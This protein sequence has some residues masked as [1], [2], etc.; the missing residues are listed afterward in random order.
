M[1]RETER[2]IEEREADPN[3]KASGLES[4]RKPNG[5]RRRANMSPPVGEP[6]GS[7]NIPAPAGSRSDR[8]SER[9]SYRVYA[10][11]S[12]GVGH[13]QARIRS[14]NDLD[15]LVEAF[16]RYTESVT[17]TSTLMFERSLA[18]EK[19][20][21]QQTLRDR[22]QK[23]YPSF[24][25]LAEDHD[26]LSEKAVLVAES[27]DDRVRQNG[28]AQE[29]AVRTLLSSIMPT[30]AQMNGSLQREIS[31]LK[32]D[33]HETRIELHDMRNNGNWTKEPKTQTMSNFEKQRAELTASVNKVQALV[34]QNREFLAHMDQANKK[35]KELAQTVSGQKMELQG[36]LDDFASQKSASRTLHESWTA[37]D[38]DH[39]Q[40]TENL[41]RTVETLMEDYNAHKKR[42]EPK[43]MRQEK[44]LESLA[45]DLAAQQKDFAQYTES[46]K[47][48]LETTTQ[49]SIS[50]KEQ[51][52]LKIM[53]QEMKLGKLNEDF[54]VEKAN[55]KRLNIE[56]VGDPE[57]SDEEFK[58]LIDYIRESREKS[59]KV[60]GV[61][62]ELDKEVEGFTE[63]LQKVE[64]GLLMLG[65]REPNPESAT[66]KADET[67]H[68][69]EA[70]SSEILLSLEERVKGIAIDQ[71][72]KD[73]LVSGEVERLDNI[74]ITQENAIKDVQNELS[75]L[76]SKAFSETTKK[77]PTP[78]PQTENQ[79]K[80]DESLLLKV[81][82]LEKSFRQFK[83]TSTERT[84]SMEV[85][86][87][88]QQQRF[89]N[90]ST[91]H[92]ANSIIH[93]MQVLYP[94]HPANVHTKIDQIKAKQSAADLHILNFVHVMNKLNDNNQ[95]HQNRIEEIQGVQIPSLDQ[96]IIETTKVV[97]DLLQES[98][99]RRAELAAL[100]VDCQ[101][102]QKRIAE[103]PREFD[104]KLEDLRLA[105]SDRLEKVDVTCRDSLSKPSNN[106]SD[107]KQD[108]S[109]LTISVDSGTR[110]L[111]ELT[112]E[113]LNGQ[114]NS[115]LL[116]HDLRHDLEGQNKELENVRNSITS[117]KTEYASTTT[118]L[119]TAVEATQMRLSDVEATITKELASLHGSL[120]ILK[121]P[122]STHDAPKRDPSLVVPET[123]TEIL[124]GE[125]L[126]SDCPLA[127]KTA[128]ARS[129]RNTLVRTSEKPLKRKRGGDSSDE[130]Y[131]SD[132][133]PP[134]AR[135]MRK[136]NRGIQRAQEGIKKR[137]RASSDGGEH[138]G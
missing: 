132:S 55:L 37:Q 137:L 28:D 30:S 90:L 91:D 56:I 15:S 48:D 45:E 59:D 108:L 9:G 82:D 51:L 117:W 76:R 27:F 75:I 112:K 26:R 100:T 129:L 64:N 99:R 18:K 87:E 52:T 74:L 11:P 92:L 105:L 111:A 39:A 20:D 44:K 23:H 54:V 134:V 102:L 85:L 119:N 79:S 96:R 65:S 126:D 4:R 103:S 8:G 128:P 16:A 83:E 12:K 10:T 131:S 133:D 43:M 25:S 2:K 47:N 57:R 29:N 93:Q 84:D 50:Q 35:I 61:I 41:K 72:E 98:D 123:Q 127:L 136:S 94:P 13:S 73:D 77:P 31:S 113:L 86:V 49:D 70:A 21:K 130:Y 116:S 40:N 120:T 107:V 34:D 101:I 60:E 110:D 3:D 97:S 6:S 5:P 104:Q 53:E 32:V 46:H 19:A 124:T 122:S 89:D 17:N 68:R 80:P 114:K 1:A 22:W 33:L 24:I 67:L 14:P 58:G 69:L 138:R 81:E 7:S 71:E 42:L 63:K 36:L 106:D 121:S 125:E 66:P 109:G 38:K 78:P 88:S 95:I 118:S 115:R 135:P 62:L